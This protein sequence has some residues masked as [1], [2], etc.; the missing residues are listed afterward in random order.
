ML[1]EWDSKIEIKRKLKR[2]HGLLNFV[3]G[4]FLFLTKLMLV[5]QP[6]YEYKLF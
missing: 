3:I 2:K 4:L 6:K 5:T 1:N